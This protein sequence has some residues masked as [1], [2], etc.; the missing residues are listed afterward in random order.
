MGAGCRGVVGGGGCR[1]VGVQGCRAEYLTA[2]HRKERYMQC[3]SNFPIPE[4]MD[5]RT[6]RYSLLEGLL[7]P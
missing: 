7:H 1:G 3:L 6:S 2:P 5:S 4:P